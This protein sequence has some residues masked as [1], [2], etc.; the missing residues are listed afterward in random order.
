MDKTNINILIVLLAIL[1][2][3]LSY[4]KILT[5]SKGI[6]KVSGILFFKYFFR[7]LIT[8]L[9]VYLSFDV[10]NQTKL[11]NNKNPTLVY[12]YQSDKIH[13]HDY[14]VNFKNYVLNDI[15]KI[16]DQTNYT[17]MRINSGTGELFKILPILKGFQLITILNN[18]QIQN[19]HGYPQKLDQK[20]Q[21]SL[22]SW[23]HDFYKFKMDKNQIVPYQKESNDFLNQ[24]Q[25]NNLNITFNL[26]VYLLFLLIVIL[27]SDI[28]LSLKII[29]I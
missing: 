1:L 12:L 25:S 19:L 28:L 11:E 29:K 9:F 17:I 10:S 26:K 2:L 15:N 24:I 8:L 14:E 16:D 27:T 20:V 4:W 22:N 5:I 6:F 18:T 23:G 21:S 13:S 3:A 7:L